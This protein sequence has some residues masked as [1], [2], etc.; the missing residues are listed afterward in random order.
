MTKNY[1]KHFC[2]SNR[3]Y[4]SVWVHSNTYFFYKI[5]KLLTIISN[6]LTENK[7]IF[8]ETGKTGGK[9]DAKC[10]QSH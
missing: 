3:I 2:V 5:S 10:Q 4:G 8:A 6:F 7:A 1:R 9:S